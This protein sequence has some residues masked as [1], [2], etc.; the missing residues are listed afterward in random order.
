[1]FLNYKYYLNKFNFVA[2]IK[3]L[4]HKICNLWLQHRG[5]TFFG[6]LCHSI[7]VIIFFTVYIELKSRLPLVPHIDGLENAIQFLSEVLAII[8]GVLIIGFTV[9]LSSYAGYENLSALMQQLRDSTNPFFA[10]FFAGGRNRH[11]LNDRKFRRRLLYRAKVKKLLFKICSGKDGKDEGWFIYRPHWDGVWYQ[12]ANSPFYRSNRNKYYLLQIQLLHE[13]VICAFKVLE[14][15]NEFRISDAGLL[16]N[17]RGSNGTKWFLEYFKE[18]KAKNNF[19]LSSELSLEDA[20]TAVSLALESEHY[21]QEEFQ[22][23]ESNV[24]WTSIVLTNFQLKYVDYIKNMTYL[25]QKLQ[26]LR[27]ANINKRCNSKLS[28]SQYKTQITESLWLNKLTAL[29]KDLA[30]IRGKIVSSYGVAKYF[31]NLKWRSIPGLALSS[32]VLILL[33]FGWPYLKWASGMTLRIEVFAF[34]YAAT[35]ASVIESFYFLAFL[36][37]KQKGSA[38]YK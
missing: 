24:N 16:S 36:I 18:Y 35:I 5:E 9:S 22:E 23:H 6:L 25:I 30:S 3:Q 2:K 15:I 26:I 10:E 4:R 11:K 31:H 19:E 33:L 37:L 12:V 29:R 20:I 32:F 7:T 28:Q 38:A 34:L 17:K 8:M 13:A 21:M 27:F 14:S 1:M